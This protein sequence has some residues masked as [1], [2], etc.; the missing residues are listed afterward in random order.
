MYKFET[1][2]GELLLAETLQYEPCV[3][4]YF[5]RVLGLSSAAGSD[6][7]EELMQQLNAR[8]V[9][10]TAPAK[11][12]RLK[13]LILTLAADLLSEMRS[14]S[15]GSSGQQIPDAVHRGDEVAVSDGISAEEI[16]EEEELCSLIETL[17]GMP[18]QTRRVVTLLK[19][20]D[21]TIPEV[22]QHLQLSTQEVVNHLEKAATAIASGSFD[23]HPKLRHRKRFG[24]KARRR[25]R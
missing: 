9:Q 17:Q 8:I 18:D 14:S 1:L 24:R 3:R 25:T 6:L 23:P 15:D 22:A 20:Y 12:L 13:Q 11:G 4:A 7:L 16:S 21:Y 2:P 10:M 5:R 19:I